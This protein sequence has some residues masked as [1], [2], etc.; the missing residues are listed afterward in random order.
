MS[1]LALA[2]VSAPGWVAAVAAGA[3]VRAG[4]ERA[5][6]VAHEV[7]GPL[8]AAG[9]VVHGAAR[10][11]ELPAALA[12]PLHLELRRAALALEDP[13]GRRRR[14]PSEA[15]T[16]LRALLRC[17]LTGWRALAAARGAQVTLSGDGG[18]LLVRADGLRLAQATANLVAN[19]LEH[20][21]GEVEVRSGLVGGRVRVEVRD[22]GPG[23]P[24]RRARARR[25][26]RGRGLAIAGRL[27]AGQ[28]GA[29]RPLPSAVGA[30]VA[31]ELPTAWPEP[32]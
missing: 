22:H 21:G 2:L 32:R 5:A 28:G 17:Q 13:D 12:A 19:A 23:L 11:G 16:D 26:G 30:R 7:R 3:R 4:R 1:A 15:A 10:R 8:T 14:P 20:G 31:L 27:V 6:R 25:G 18:P 9:L 29:L 24:A